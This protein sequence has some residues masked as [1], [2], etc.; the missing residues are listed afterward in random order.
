MAATQAQ[1]DLEYLVMARGPDWIAQREGQDWR[2]EDLLR[3]VTWLKSLVPAQDMTRRLDTAREGL[4]AAREDWLRG[5]RAPSHDRADA[6]AWMVFQG[7]TFG[8]GRRYSLIDEAARIAP[9]LIRLGKELDVLRAIPGAEARA[10]KLMMGDRRQPEPGL[11]ELL[12]ALAWRRHG[13]TVAFV[14]EDRRHPTPDL[15]VERPRRRWSVECKRLMPAQY[16]V[17][18]RARGEVLAEPVH[19]LCR[20][21]GLSAVVHV[22][23]DVE[24]A[25]VGDDYLADKLRAAIE[26]NLPEFEWQDETGRGRIFP[27]A[28]PL[29]R[30]VMAHDD[31][32]Y[33]SSRMIEL[34]T[35]RYE[36]QA[37]HSFSGDWRP[38]DAHLFHAHTL[39]RGSV[40]SWMSDS[41]DA[42]RQKARHF[43][44]VITH[45]ENQLDHDRPGVVHVGV[46]SFGGHMTDAFRHFRNLVE[47]ADYQPRNPRLRWVYG[48]YFAPEVSTDPDETWG[49]DESMAPYRIGRHRTA[50]PL[51]NHLLV[52]P[53]DGM[54]AGVHWDRPRRT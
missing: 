54:R 42:R 40:I 35:G 46:E 1:W 26:M 38:S 24:L 11:Y 36:Y 37:D 47:A 50:W 32:F 22:R 7:E 28:W 15:R 51:P 44:R 30:K 19:R 43:K 27:P 5:G 8:E 23:Y 33:G 31:V 29:I 17:L 3:A 4:M 2:D 13:W 10:A 53:E 18:E 9:Y 48:N 16:T 39:Y 34:F 45:A 25:H 20:E 14:P 49:F 21:Q 6:A 52:S 41:F 12:V